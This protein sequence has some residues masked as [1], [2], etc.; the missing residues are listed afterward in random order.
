M[1]AQ[2]SAEVQ[3]WAYQWHPEV[4]ILVSFLIGAYI[5][6]VF[7]LARRADNPRERARAPEALGPPVMPM[8]VSNE[9]APA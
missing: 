7:F 2:V 9:R 8:I 6:V 4:W 3:P 5:S 1:I